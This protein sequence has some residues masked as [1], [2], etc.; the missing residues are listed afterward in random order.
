MLNMAADS[1]PT[2]VSPTT[3]A[4]IDEIYANQDRFRTTKRQAELLRTF[5][6]IFVVL[7]IIFIYTV[8]VAVGLSFPFSLSVLF[9]FNA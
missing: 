7:L 8:F 9:C 2:D 4:A 6:V 1:S 5:P 3:A